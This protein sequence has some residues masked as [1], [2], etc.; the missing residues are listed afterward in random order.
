MGREF[1][2]PKTALGGEVRSGT[3]NAF[4]VAVQQGERGAR[5]PATQD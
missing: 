1:T 3:G 5:S 4:A 2:G